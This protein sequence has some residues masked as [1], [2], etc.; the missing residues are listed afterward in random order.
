[1]W[2]WV[3]LIIITIGLFGCSQTTEDQK[4]NDDEKDTQQEDQSVSVAEKANSD[5]IVAKV[6]DH[7]ITGEDL[8]YEMKR[9]ALISKLQGAEKKQEQPSS[10]IAIQ[11]L[12]RNHIIHQIAQEEG[13]TVDKSKQQKRAQSV[14]QDVESSDG[15]TD[16]MQGID[17]EKFWSREKDRYEIILEAEKL[18][19]KL[20]DGVQKKHPDYSKQALKFDAQ[21]EL[22]EIIQEE[23]A[24][25]N[26]EIYD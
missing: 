6:A 18:I 14:R 10:Q 22:E 7:E 21:K 17:E 4:G 9:L 26:V 24:E 15:Y 3:M 20:M 2:K 19:T 13:I 23:L 8:H 16:L 5:T 12:I 25:T 1:M 11:E